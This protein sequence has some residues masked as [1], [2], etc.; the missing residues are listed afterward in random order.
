MLAAKVGIDGW[1][2]RWRNLLRTGD[3]FTTGQVLEKGVGVERPCWQLRTP[4]TP[5]EPQG[6]Q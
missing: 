5:R 1:E 2:M 4:T 6:A 3:V